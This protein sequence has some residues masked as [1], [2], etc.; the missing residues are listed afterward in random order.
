MK[1]MFKVF[2]LLFPILLSAQ[3]LDHGELGPLKKSLNNKDY[4]YKVIDDPTGTAP[5]KKVERFE[6]RNGDCSKNPWWDDC[7]NDRERV[8]L[9]QRVESQASKKIEWYGWSFFV[10]KNFPSVYPVKLSIAQFYDDGAMQPVWMFQVN[11]GGLYIESMMK[12]SKV[13]E[14]IIPANELSNRWHSIEVEV[15]WSTQ[16][17]G[18]L[19]VWVD[20]NRKLSYSGQTLISGKYYLKY[21]LYRSYLSRFK[22]KGPIP[23]QS[24]YFS[25]VK[26][27]KTQKNIQP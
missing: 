11:D 9:M 22:K 24:I 5:F 10:D 27:G 21:G 3:E 14:Y 26:M 12:T 19:N 23:T 7:K 1:M 8:E 2:I 17:D 25:N 4:A 15:K 13:Q 20:K 16:K 6:L 18:F